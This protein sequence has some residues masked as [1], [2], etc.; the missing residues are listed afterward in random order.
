MKL[1]D[2]FR[3]AWRWFSMQCM[4]WALALQGAWEFCP[5]ELKAGV[6]PRAVTVI[7][8]A[9]LVMGLIGRLVKQEPKP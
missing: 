6:P 4:A 2:D 1:V 3:S 8:L 7:T 5:P 9:L